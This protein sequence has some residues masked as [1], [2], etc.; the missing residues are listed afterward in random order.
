[1]ALQCGP[2]G[3]QT[4][5]ELLLEQELISLWGP[6]LAMEVLQP[7]S[8]HGRYWQGPEMAQLPALWRCLHSVLGLLEAWLAV[9]VPCVMR[10][11]LLFALQK[12]GII[13]LLTRMPMGTACW[14]VECRHQTC[15]SPGAW[16]VL[17]GP[18]DDGR[19]MSKLSKNAF[20]TFVYSASGMNPA[21]RPA[22]ICCALRK[23][24]L[25]AS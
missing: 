21:S 18:P 4:R 15:A 12:T 19:P 3:Q 11:A 14:G 2:A 1:M 16:F 20:L 7:P 8:F 24:F 25:T 22:L 5:S 13:P 17:V 9:Q 23:E 6:Q 10:S